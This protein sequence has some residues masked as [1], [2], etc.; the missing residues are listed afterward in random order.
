MNNL[1]FKV[2]SFDARRNATFV[3]VEN[4]RREV[5]V[6]ADVLKKAFITRA[7]LDRTLIDSAFGKC[8]LSAEVAQ[9][10]GGWEATK[11]WLNLEMNTEAQNNNKGEFK[12]FGLELNKPKNGSDAFSDLTKTEKVADKLGK[13]FKKDGDL[14]GFAFDNDFL[15]LLA[16][17]N[18]RN[19]T[20][21]SPNGI[22]KA[23]FTPDWRTV[24]GMGEASVYET[25]MTLHPV[26]G[27]P[28]IPAST[29]KGILRHH[30]D[31]SDRLKTYSEQIFGKN[32]N[33]SIKKGQAIFFDAFPIKA[34]RVELDVMTPHYPDYYGGDKPPADWQSPNPIHF[35]TI[36]KGTI[37]QFLVGLPENGENQNFAETLSTE[38]ENAFTDRGLGAKTAVGYGYWEKITL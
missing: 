24:T 10:N 30:F 4:T 3:E 36:G 35:L 26:Y 6:P 25:N 37:F 32:E 38:L 13:R 33:D 5:F 21:I 2:N 15:G 1:K 8:L 19:A 23:K 7:Y 16:A 14:I 12:N 18:L 22:V 31:E 11:V 17:R 20:A 34:P 9:K 28:Y 29:I 27:V